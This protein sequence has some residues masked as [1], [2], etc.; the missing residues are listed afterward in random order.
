MNWDVYL[1]ADMGPQPFFLR[2]GTCFRDIVALFAGL[3][4]ED[5]LNSLYKMSSEAL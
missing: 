3:C 5:N 4:A 1:A 2:V